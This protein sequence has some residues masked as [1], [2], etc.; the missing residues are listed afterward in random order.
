MNHRLLFFPIALTLAASHATA[1]G[2]PEIGRAKAALC[3]AC[4][5]T[6]GN[7]AAPIFPKLAGQQASYIEKQITEFHSGFRKDPVM[8]AQVATVALDDVPHI[9]AYFASQKIQHS[10]SK[11]DM[12]EVAAIGERL[13]RGG[14]PVSHVPACSGC[15]GPQG[16][17]N[18]AAKIPRIGGQSP[19]YVTKALKDFHS[20]TRINDPNGMMRGATAR[21]ADDEIAALSQYIQ[22]L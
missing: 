20:G 1:D 14:N 22:G 7:S 4:H 19:E 21:L 5:G 6:D 11:P 9:A 15:H 16:A 13:Y 12:A 10:E 8:S 18:S 17:G 3:G 2:D